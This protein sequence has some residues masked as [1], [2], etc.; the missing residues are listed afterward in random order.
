MNSYS[1]KEKIEWIVPVFFGCLGSLVI[2][3][4]LAVRQPDISRY[5]E[6]GAV[7]VHTE[8]DQE[9]FIETETISVFAGT[10]PSRR[11]VIQEWYRRSETRT[12][13]IDFFAGICPSRE[14][15][16][17]VLAYAD[18]FNIPPAL[19]FSLAWEESRFNHRAVNNKNLDESI[20]RGLFQLNNR[21]FPRLDL[22]AFFN[23]EVNARYGM[24]HLRY[25]LDTGGSEIVA[26]AMYN[27]GSGRVGSSGTPKST[28]DYINRILENRQKI[29]NRFREREVL[30]QKH[31]EDFPE[32]A[33][34][35]KP[36]PPL[37]VPLKP[38]AGI[39]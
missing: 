19:A 10:G 4:L 22:N 25:C 2:C 7:N 9:I 32:L 29:E 23:P 26:L 17:T 24:G 31:E 36:S 30:Y 11:D 1:N 34:E 39:R 14:V 38:L 13:V 37:L 28:L 21:S 12:F 27:A 3:T 6:S 20:D 5:P 18:L 35:V 16:E 33:A 8:V 15:A